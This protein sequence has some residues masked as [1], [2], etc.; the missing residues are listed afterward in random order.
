MPLYV[1]ARITILEPDKN[2]TQKWQLVL[3]PLN[4]VRC[5]NT[6]GAKPLHKAQEVHTMRTCGL[7]NNG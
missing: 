4:S 2:I 5:S 3:I 7:D 6:T 1:L